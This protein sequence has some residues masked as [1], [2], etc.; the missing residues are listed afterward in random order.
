M[1]RVTDTVE[2][3]S[4]ASRKRFSLSRWLE[5]HT[6][7]T[8]PLLISVLALGAGGIAVV[9]AH[10]GGRATAVASTPTPLPVPQNIL[11]QYGWTNAS[12]PT[13]GR[14][15]YY[16]G[17]DGRIFLAG[18]LRPTDHAQPTAFL[19]PSGYRPALTVVEPVAVGNSFGTVT[20]QPTGGVVLNLPS[21]RKAI[22]SLDG[23]S[24]LPSS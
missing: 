19:L 3:R 22:V 4:V 1:A 7:T 15:A 16:K 2:S 17:P 13:A 10:R 12:T 9:L 11:S 8:L 23:V 5:A 18:A 20:I 21:K 14:A 6:S 24:F